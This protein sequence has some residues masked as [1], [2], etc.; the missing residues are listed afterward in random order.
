MPLPDSGPR[1][2]LHNRAIRFE[3]FIREDGLWEVEGFLIDQKPYD[4]HNYREVLHPAG[5]PVHDIGVRVTLNDAQEVVDIHATLDASPYATCGSG[6]KETVR[7]KLPQR[8]A[9]THLNELLIALATVVFQTRGFGKTPQGTSPLRTLRESGEHPFFVGK[10][11]SW[12]QDSDTV[13]EV[14]PLLH[15]PR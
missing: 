9:C 8:L 1:R 15:R 12:R 3:G 14:F 11:L 13:R 4:F 2:P 7:A 5:Q 6:W 10:C